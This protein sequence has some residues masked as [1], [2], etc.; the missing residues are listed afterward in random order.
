MKLTKGPLKVIVTDGNAI[1]ENAARARNGGKIFNP[2]FIVYEYSHD[3]KSLD[4][5]YAFS[6][7][8][9]ALRPRYA[10]TKFPYAW[11]PSALQ[12]TRA[13]LETNDELTLVSNY[14]PEE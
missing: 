13:W 9:K 7:Q 8:S 14:S 2:P 5:H 1:V 10:L 6:Y 3:L 12:D 4:R 11:A